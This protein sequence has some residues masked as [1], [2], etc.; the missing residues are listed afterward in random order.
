[1]LKIFSTLLMVAIVAASVFAHNIHRYVNEP[2]SNQ[3]DVVE[4]AVD[5]G[6]TFNQVSQRLVEAGFITNPLYFKLLAM[7]EEKTQSIK[8][9]EYRFNTKQ[10]PAQILDDL[11]Q[12][13]T[14][15]YKLTIIEGKRFQD[16]FQQLQDHPKIT[17]VIDDVDD[18][19]AELKIEQSSLEGLFFPDTYTFSAGTKDIDVIRQS[20]NL[21][22]DFLDQE[23][24][25]RSEESFVSSPY[26][27]LILASI[28]EKETSVESERPVIAGVFISRLSK[29]MPL[30]TDPTVIY[31][32]GAEFDGN[33]TRK[34]LQTDNPFNT[35]TRRGLPPSPI[36]LVGKAAILAVLHPQITGDLYF[37][38]KNDGTHYF[39]KTYKEHLEAVRKYQLKR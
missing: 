8:S 39:S 30:Q 16:F 24:P 22:R 13:N 6:A 5:Q 4:I 15:Q 25:K 11:V 19:K 38:S 34:H 3:N 23:W 17:R 2:I 21:L 1:M 31:G 28:V 36:A 26:E 37:V 14:M 9:G 35:Y 10:S 20:H 29:K 33:L 18:I 32:L 27:A 7:Y 12:G